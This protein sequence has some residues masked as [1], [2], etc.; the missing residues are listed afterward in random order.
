MNIGC[1]EANISPTSTLS[2]SGQLPAAPS[3][4]LDQSRARMASDASPPESRKLVS[5]SV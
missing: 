5:P 2:R 4:E 1:F 3:A